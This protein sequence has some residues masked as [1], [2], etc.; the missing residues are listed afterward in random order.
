MVGTHSVGGRPSFR[1]TRLAV[2]FICRGHKH[3]R[4]IEHLWFICVCV[5]VRVYLCILHQIEY[6]ILT[7]AFASP[8]TN[9]KKRKCLCNSFLL[10][11]CSILE[12]WNVQIEIKQHTAHSSSADLMVTLVAVTVLIAVWDPCTA[13][14]SALILCPRLRF[15][16]PFLVHLFH[17]LLPLPPSVKPAKPSPR[18][19]WIHIAATSE[20][21]HY[22]TSALNK[23]DNAMGCCCCCCCCTRAQKQRKTRA[24]DYFGR[25]AGCTHRSARKTDMRWANTMQ[26]IV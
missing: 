15:M 1:L 18:I 10:S 25:A 5:C 8:S 21:G 12:R 26:F 16:C 11:I 3:K 20:R 9:W 22:L 19:Y 23:P 14:I 13:A 6:Y 2:L 24:L 4:T 17:F 7:F